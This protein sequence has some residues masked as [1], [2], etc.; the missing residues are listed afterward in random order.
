MDIDWLDEFLTTHTR[1]SMMER[2]EIPKTDDA[3]VPPY[4]D[5]ETVGAVSWRRLL[6][7]V[8]INNIKQS[9]KYRVDFATATPKGRGRVAMN[10]NNSLRGAARRRG[11]LYAMVGKTKLWHEAPASWLKVQVEQDFSEPS[12]DRDG[13]PL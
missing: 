9:D 10:I 8:E 11:G 5:I 3:N 4:V 1:V 2:I 12:E 6:Q 7:L 13:N